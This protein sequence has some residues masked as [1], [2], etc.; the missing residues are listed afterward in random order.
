MRKFETG[1]TR[2]DDKTKLDYEGF[3][4]PI[5][6]ERFAQYMNKHQRQADGLLRTSDN[7]Q[8]GI[9]KDAYVKSLWRHFFDVWKQYRGYKS[10][11]E[12]EDSLCAVMFNTMGYLFEVLKED[13][14]IITREEAKELE[15]KFAYWGC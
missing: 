1:A 11:E 12:L 3:L 7:W 9:P 13:K 4:S 8:R 2:D 6:L 10:V 5:V 15:E 14:Q